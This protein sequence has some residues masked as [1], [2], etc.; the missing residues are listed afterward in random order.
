MHKYFDDIGR[1]E[2]RE[3]DKEGIDQC[4]GHVIEVAVE[5]HTYFYYRY[6]REYRCHYPYF[7]DLGFAC[8]RVF[9]FYMVDIVESGLIGFVIAEMHS[10]IRLLVYVIVE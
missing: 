5:P 4:F 1:F 8:S 9:V 3:D 6:D 7:F 10:I 2:E